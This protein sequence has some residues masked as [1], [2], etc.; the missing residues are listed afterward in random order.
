MNRS[1][2]HNLLIVSFVLVICVIGTVAA[3]PFNYKLRI[4]GVTPHVEELKNNIESDDTGYERRTIESILTAIPQTE[5]IEWTGGR[6]D[7][8]NQWLTTA[9][10]EFAAETDFEKKKIILNSIS[11]RLAAISASVGEL[12][13]A[14]KA[15][16]TKDADK[17]KLA[18]ILSRQEY[19]KPEVKEESLFQK[20]WRAF[21][22]WLRDKFPKPDISP[23]DGP[24]LAPIKIILQ[25]VIFAAVIG[26]VGFLLWR[27]VP[28]FSNRFGSRAGPEKGG[29]VI[30]GE[31]VG[32]DRSP[33]DL[34]DD[35]ERLAR[36]GDLR[37]AIRKGYIAVLCELGDQ[38]IVRLA[39]HKTN[40]DYLRDVSKRERIFDGMNHLTN[41]FERNWYGLREVEAADWEDFCARYHVTVA[42]A[43]GRL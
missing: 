18:D 41:N 17:Q 23:V 26:L 3:T 38:K 33:S 43:K 32:E 7:T 11:E 10:N 42:E 1:Y 31:T 4:D 27:F 36:Q 16:S 22:E 34:F 6:I 13:K 39:S 19:Q 30:L 25:V 20:W 40:R 5:K 14:I 37:S 28:Y 29:R 9:L 24:N 21:S 12:D 8:D 15:E 2:T 35:A